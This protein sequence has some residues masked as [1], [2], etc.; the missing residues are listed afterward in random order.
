MP[1]DPSAHIGDDAAI[2]RRVEATARAA[3]GH[4]DVRVFLDTFMDVDRGYYTR[5]GLI[6]RRCHPRPASWRLAGS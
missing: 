5:N 4:P 3:A 1:D 6:D 2:A